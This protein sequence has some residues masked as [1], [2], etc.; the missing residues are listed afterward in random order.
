MLCLVLI[1]VLDTIKS[2]HAAEDAVPRG[3]GMRRHNNNIRRNVHTHLNELRSCSAEYWSAVV[4]EPPPFQ[5]PIVNLVH[6]I[7]A[8]RGQH[9][10]NFFCR[11]TDAENCRDLSGQHELEII[12]IHQYP[13]TFYLCK[14]LLELAQPSRMCKIPRAKKVQ[15]L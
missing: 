7:E 11:P 14:F 2:G 12:F 13:S 8:G 4:I 5:Q 3:E 15:A 10:M 9:M 1:A 6:D